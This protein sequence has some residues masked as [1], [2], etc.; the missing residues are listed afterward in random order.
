[1]LRNSIFE[2]S[3]TS[4]VQSSVLLALDNVHVEHN[5]HNLPLRPKADQPRAGCDPSNSFQIIT[6]RHFFK[7]SGQN[8]ANPLSSLIHICG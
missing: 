6:F 7:I 2:V 1:M 5:I 8:P 3:R 4:L